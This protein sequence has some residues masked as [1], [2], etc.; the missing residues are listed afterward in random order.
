MW[1]TVYEWCTQNNLN[2]LKKFFVTL[3]ENNSKFSCF[4]N[5]LNYLSVSKNST[6]LHRAVTTGSREMVALL[7]DLGADPSIR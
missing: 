5:H 1:N 2:E 4:G 7:L 3:N 6:L